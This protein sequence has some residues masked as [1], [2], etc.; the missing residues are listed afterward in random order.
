MD[1]RLLGRIQLPPTIRSLLEHRLVEKDGEG[2]SPTSVFRLSFANEILYLKLVHNKYEPTS[3]SVE[4]EKDV[5][6]WLSGRL[7]V[8]RVIDYAETDDHQFLVM[9]QVEGR[10]LADLRDVPAS[11]VVRLFAEAIRQVQCVGVNDCPFD[12]C[13]DV[14]LSELKYLLDAGLAATED[15]RD[16]EV[17][18][19]DPLELYQ[20]L[21]AHRPEQQVVFS[22]GDMSDGNLFIDNSPRLG[23]VD[24]GR[25]GK[26]DIWCDIAHAMQNI[27]AEL[28]SQ[29]VDEFFELLGMSPD[30]DRIRYHLWLD[31]LF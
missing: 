20:R 17:P 2:E 9:S 3:Y 12:S 15:L 19:D 6:I 16:G 29:H 10:R 23:Y 26:A 1:E 5:L 18:F 24:W 11:E 22:H 28:G 4:R 25:G 14:R 31:E 7:P 8:P 21:S 13:V 27:E 30:W